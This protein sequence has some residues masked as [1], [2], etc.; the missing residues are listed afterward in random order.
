MAEFLQL[1]MRQVEIV[2]ITHRN[3]LERSFKFQ[4]SLAAYSAWRGAY[5]Q[6][7]KKLPNSPDDLT[8]KKQKVSTGPDWKKQKA[9][10]EMLNRAVEGFDKRVKKHG[11]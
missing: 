3:N 2:I 4:A 5:F 6:R 11:N 1:T 10:M 9:A 7:L 8:S